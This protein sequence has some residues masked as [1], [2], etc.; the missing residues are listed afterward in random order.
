MILQVVVNNPLMTPFPAVFFFPNSNFLHLGNKSS[1]S[2]QVEKKKSPMKQVPGMK[3]GKKIGRCLVR[4][5][6][7]LKFD[8]MLFTFKAH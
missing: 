2:P 6:E 3:T 7:I 8:D 1:A 4:I 5:N